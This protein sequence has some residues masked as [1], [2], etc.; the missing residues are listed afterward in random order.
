MVIGIINYGMGN[1]RSVANAFESLGCR[2]AILTEPQAERTVDRIVLPGV[3]AFCDG[4]NNLRSC[5]WA[6]VLEDVVLG[7]R[8]PFLGLCLGMQLLASKG[9]EHGDWEGLGWMPGVVRRL[10]PSDP[11][12]RVPHVGWNDVE[13][14][15]PDGLYRGAMG[16]QTFYFVHSYAFEPDD[17]EVVSAYCRH[18]ERFVASVERGNV[19]ATQY[20]PEKSQRCGLA[21]LRNFLQV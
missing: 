3:G 12:V 16:E 9:T 7:G 5:G 13:V 19:F 14:V 20:H 18:G 8:K 10:T 21:V 17:R 15:K 2:T 4:I 1:L 11:S 6:P